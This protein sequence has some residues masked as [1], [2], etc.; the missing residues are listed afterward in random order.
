MFSKVKKSNSLK[1]INSV[2]KISMPVS[3]ML[4]KRKR[5]ACVRGTNKK[6]QLSMSISKSKKAWSA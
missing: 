1:N 2:S 5:R 3:Q 6:Q 4:K